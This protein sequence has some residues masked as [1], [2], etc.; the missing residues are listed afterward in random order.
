MRTD[1]H[2]SHKH[3]QRPHT[4][5]HN[6][7]SIHPCKRAALPL[8]G[9]GVGQSLASAAPV[10][11]EVSEGIR[12]RQ[13]FLRLASL[14]PTE[15]PPELYCLRTAEDRGPEFR[16]PQGE[17][18]EEGTGRPASNAL[19]LSITYSSSS[20][21]SGIARALILGGRRAGLA[22]L[23]VRR[24]RGLASLIPA[25]FHRVLSPRARELP[26]HYV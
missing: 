14:R 21:S 2:T 10:F 20:S 18:E 4:S 25:Q 9:G 22:P 12:Q 19:S 26:P 15:D 23:R 8:F 24:R 1:G 6:A 11:R 13:Q 16:V 17:E 3:R 5:T 7:A